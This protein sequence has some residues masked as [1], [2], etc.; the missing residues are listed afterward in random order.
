MDSEKIKVK[1]LEHVLKDVPQEGWSQAALDKAALEVTGDETLG[2]RLFP[3]GPLEA[4]DL[5]HQLLDQE[6]LA[7]LPAPESLRVRDRV[8]EGVKTRL[9]LLAPH[10]EAARKTVWYLAHPAH[11]GQ[12]ARLLYKTVNEIWYYAGDRSTD[13]NFYTKRAL[14]AAV[15]G[16]TFTYWLKDTSEGFQ[17]TW[18][19]LDKRLEQALAFGSLPSKIFGRMRG[20]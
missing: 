18:V 17:D 15:Y 7:I 13:Y 16:A 5:W 8:R 6:M 10:R 1:I 14:L 19:F 11:L 2:W 20:G 12:G 4:I 9:L 3:K